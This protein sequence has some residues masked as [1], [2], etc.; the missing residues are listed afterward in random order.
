MRVK[1]QDEGWVDTWGILAGEE[2]T[3]ADL[4]LSDGDG[5][6]WEGIDCQPGNAHA[7]F[8]LAVRH[9]VGWRE[10]RREVMYLLKG[11]AVGRAG[12]GVSAGDGEGKMKQRKRE[13]RKRRE[14]D[15]MLEDILAVV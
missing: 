5:G 6:E 4:V 14:V 15:M 3:L 9:R 2:P 7:V 10:E 12:G 1:K 13:R 11:S 8:T